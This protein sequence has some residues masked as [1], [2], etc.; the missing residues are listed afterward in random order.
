MNDQLKAAVSVETRKFIASRVTR[1]ATAL[2]VGGIA[3]MATVF[4]AAADSGN[5]RIIAQLGDLAHEDGWTRLVGIA[6]QI[7]SVA[8]LLGFGVVMAWIMGREFADGTIS[9]LFA[10]PV[11]RGAIAVAKLTVAMVW[12]AVISI[13]LTATIVVAGLALGIGMPDA[14]AMS[15]LLRLVLLTVLSGLLAVPAA[16]AATVGRSLLPGIAVTIGLIA[17]AQVMVVVGTGAWYP[18]ALPALWAIDP[19][20]VSVTQ[21]CLVAL[22]PGAFGLATTRAWTKLQLAR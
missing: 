1:S 22:V 19:Q 18:I 16:W 3:I 5:E 11:G 9:G 20:E 13:C 12:T 2:I 10:L 17:S 21:L 6:I 14:S 8:G 7:T 4:E 15:E